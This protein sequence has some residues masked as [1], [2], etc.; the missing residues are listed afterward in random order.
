MLNLFTKTKPWVVASLLAATAAFAQDNNNTKCRPQKSFDQGHELMQNQMMPAYSA[1]ARVD[2]RG[3]WDVY[4]TGSFIYWQARQENMEIGMVSNAANPYVTTSAIPVVSYFVNPDFEYKPGFKFGLG[5]NLDWDNWDAYAEY[6]WFHG[7]TDSTVSQLVPTGTAATAGNFNFLQAKQGAP[8]AL[9]TLTPYYN[10]GNQSWNLKMDFLDMS[11]ARAYYAGMK[12]TVRPFFGARGAWIREHLDTTYNGNTAGGASATNNSVVTNSTTSWGLGPRAGFGT[13]W[14]MGYGLR[15]T[16][17]ASA[18]VLY[19]RYN[20]R[21]QQLF[22][23]TATPSVVTSNYKLSVDHLDYLRAHVCLDLGFGWGSYFDN[24]NWHVDLAASYAYQVF[25]DQNM[26]ITP[27]SAN[28]S[29]LTLSPN[30][31]LYVH[32][33]NLTARLDF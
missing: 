28:M 26:M 31:N 30:G 19:T 29:A 4:A 8:G 24:N 25:W 5:A 6:T 2:V 10:S 23:T 1:P 20:A 16:G 12:L 22:S 15:F 33:L 17:D 11:L 13:N 21:A 18:D 9:S 14:L 27:V 7:T 3:S 32:G